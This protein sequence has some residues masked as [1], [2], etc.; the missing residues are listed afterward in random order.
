LPPQAHSAL[1]AVLKP[2]VDA[3]A[4]VLAPW[5]QALLG[6][7]V[8]IGAFRLFDRFLPPVDPTG[9]SLGRMATTVFRPWVALL[10][11]M[12]MTSITLSVSVSLAL[13]VPLTVRGLVRRE[14]V[15]PFILGANITTFVDTL[16]ASVLIDDPAGFTVVFSLAASV[17]VLSIPIVFVWYRPYERLVDALAV[18]ATRDRRRLAVS[19]ALLFLVPIGLISWSLIAR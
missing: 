2:F 11:G 7:L 6:I 10:L 9:G 14:N 16:V 5:G 4:V 12:L 1:D 17:T 15:I 13:L 19:V 3:S 18:E 8:L